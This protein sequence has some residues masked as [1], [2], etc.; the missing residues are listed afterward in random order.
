MK[1]FIVYFDNAVA[2]NLDSFLEKAK[3]QF[4]QNNIVVIVYEADLEVN[5]RLKISNAKITI[6]KLT[7]QNTVTDVATN[8]M[9]TG[10]ARNDIFLYQPNALAFSGTLFQD[11]NGFWEKFIIEEPSFKFRN[12]SGSSV[13][14]NSRGATSTDNDDDDNVHIED[15]SGDESG[16]ASSCSVGPE[17]DEAIKQ[18]VEYGY[19]K[20]RH[21]EEVTLVLS[22]EKSALAKAEIEKYPEHF[23]PQFFVNEQHDSEKT[24]AELTTANQQYR[25]DSFNAQQTIGKEFYPAKTTGKAITLGMIGASLGVVAALQNY[26]FGGAFAKCFAEVIAEQ[27]DINLTPDDLENIRV[28]FA[29]IST[30][31][32]ACINAQSV[33]GAEKYLVNEINALK[34]GG[35]TQSNILRAIG[36]GVKVLGCLVV[37]MPNIQIIYD[38][39]NKVWGKNGMIAM[40]IVGNAVNIALVVRGGSNLYNT[41]TDFKGRVFGGDNREAAQKIRHELLKTLLQNNLDLPS[42]QLLSQGITAVNQTKVQ[43]VKA[44]ITLIVGAAALWYTWGAYFASGVEGADKTLKLIDPSLENTPPTAAILAFENMVSVLGAIFRYGMFLRSTTFFA[45]RIT[46]RYIAKPIVPV[47]EHNQESVSKK[48]AWDAFTLVVG[49]WGLTGGDGLVDN[50]FFDVTHDGSDKNGCPKDNT[51]TTST[52]SAVIA[53]LGVG[54]FNAKDFGDVCSGLNSTRKELLA[55]CRGNMTEF[56]K[57]VY[58]EN[59]EAFRNKSTNLLAETLD[60]DILGRYVASVQPTNVEVGESAP[61][62]SD[63]QQ[64][65]AITV[66]NETSYYPSQRYQDLQKALAELK[67]CTDIEYQLFLQENPLEAVADLLQAAQA[68]ANA[69]GAS[70]T[71]YSATGAANLGF[72]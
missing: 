11:F 45:E 38:A 20:K 71:S 40:E 62:L 2:N 4:Q 72:E 68:R 3:K 23:R 50:Y 14:Q 54:P 69:A 25:Q 17:T 18:L 64:A 59:L 60:A 31:V 58:G 5:Q 46:Q 55:R 56:N 53:G 28:P 57:S 63:N 13:R 6:E 48:A 47:A 34:A 8:H 66:V 41:A 16:A 10:T 51:I 19:H 67:C 43:A 15:G 29:V 30:L 9:P 12:S 49:L 44:F 70:A 27:H 33:I 52:A 39:F 24:I 1:L 21:G 36:F 26:Y 32:N 35:C 65:R 37:I 22:S 7:N 61:L 42:Q